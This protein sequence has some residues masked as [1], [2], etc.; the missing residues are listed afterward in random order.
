M[1][2]VIPSHIRRPVFSTFRGLNA[3]L[4][5]FLIT[6]DGPKAVEVRYPCRNI[7]QRTQLFATGSCAQ[8]NLLPVY[9]CPLHGLCSPLGG[10]KD[11]DSVTV[12]ADGACDDFS[13]GT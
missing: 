4:S 12:C 10:V 11:A 6:G 2:C 8:L 3:M 13:Q 9:K 5:D 1:L 7:G